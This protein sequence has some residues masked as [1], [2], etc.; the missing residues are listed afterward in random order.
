MVVPVKNYDTNHIWAAPPMHC[1]MKWCEPAECIFC[2]PGLGTRRQGN[3]EWASLALLMLTPFPN[4]SVG[5][6]H[7]NSRPSMWSCLYST[8]L[9]RSIRMHVNAIRTNRCSCRSRIQ[10][11][12]KAYDSSRK[13]PKCFCLLSSSLYEISKTDVFSGTLP[14]QFLKKY[15]GV[16]KN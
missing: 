16:Y 11:A 4:F 13:F 8:V 1:Y 5:Y 3:N 12:T 15:L 14:E 9:A 6:G 2:I 10:T 7:S